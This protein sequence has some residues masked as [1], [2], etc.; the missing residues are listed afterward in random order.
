MILNLCELWSFAFDHQGEK[1]LLSS[2]CFFH[3]SKCFLLGF[4]ADMS[5]WDVPDQD[6]DLPSIRILASLIEFQLP[7]GMGGLGM[8]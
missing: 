8:S 7:M 1:F 6:L 3:G 4:L 5:L 2:S